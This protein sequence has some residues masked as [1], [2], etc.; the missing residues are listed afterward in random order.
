MN[1]LTKFNVILF[2][3]IALL[4]AT[5]VLITY[6]EVKSGIE[7]FA[8]DKARSDLDLVYEM[9]DARYEGP[10]QI[11]NDELY[12]GDQRI[13]EAYE[14]ADEIGDLTNGLVTAFQGRQPVMTNLIIGGERAVSVEA[15]G[16]VTERVLVNAERYFGE[17]N[18][19]GEDLQTAYRPI[20]SEDGEILGM[21]F[22]A[23]SQEAINDTMSSILWQVLLFTGTVVVLVAIF[24]LIFMRN[25]RRRIRN[26]ISG[27]RKAGEGDLSETIDIQGHDELSLIANSFNQMSEN[28]RGLLNN[29]KEASEHLSS[30]S[31]E[32]SATSLQSTQSASEVKRSVEE[33]SKG[34]MSQADDTERGAM[35]IASLGDLIDHEQ[36]YVSD[37]NKIAE[38]INKLKDEGMT[39]VKELVS[40]TEENQLVTTEVRDMIQK[41]NA[42]TEK[43]E[44]ASGMIRNIS[45]QTNLLALNAS[46]EAARAGEGGKGF[47]VVADEI[48][49]LAEQSNTFSEE[50]HT[51]INKLSDETSD[52]VEKMK[53]SEKTMAV[54]AGSVND[55]T[56]TFNGLAVNIEK[57]RDKINQLNKSGEQMAAK[58]QAIVSIIENLSAISEENAASTEEMTAAIQQQASA[59]EEIAKSSEDLANLAEEMENNVSRFQY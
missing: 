22:T 15:T 25:I 27:L 59:M 35:G 56:E 28:L 2:S 44:N 52:A 48:R 46:I 14:L 8:S 11:V 26:L 37:M 42:S 1:I 31:E 50:I 10:Y 47:A 20:V 13:N 36:G 39:L 6:G 7:D 38:G 51:I 21:W 53:Q 33:I 30:S 43:I 24:I 57:M 17:A 16:E 41:T 49:K 18:I 5:I 45:E 3:V 9:V 12:K 34:A 32:L 55:T 40:K 19:L 23:A 4:S 29:L 58:K 54:Q